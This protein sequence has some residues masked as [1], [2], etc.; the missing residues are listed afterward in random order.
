MQLNNTTPSLRISSANNYGVTSSTLGT[1]ISNACRSTSWPSMVRHCWITLCQ[2]VTMSSGLQSTYRRTSAGLLCWMERVWPCTL[3]LIHK[4]KASM[5][6]IYCLGIRIL[7]TSISADRLSDRLGIKR[8]T[9][10]SF[11]VFTC[12]DDIAQLPKRRR[13]GV[14]LCNT[15]R[16]DGALPQRPPNRSPERCA[17]DFEHRPETSV[18]SVHSVKTFHSTS[19]I[20]LAIP[21]QLMTLGTKFS[22][23]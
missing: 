22:W 12:K 2:M 11:Y 23:G 6:R 21:A 13:S 16:T 15:L 18:A 7:R 19:S 5:K 1:I 10:H 17:Y 14:S 8:R 4:G 20:S 3:G 9:T